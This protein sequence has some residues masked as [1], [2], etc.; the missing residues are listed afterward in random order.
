MN[1]TNDDN[2][3][4]WLSSKEMQKSLKISDCEL[5]HLR[6]AGKLQFKKLGNAF[7]YQLPGTT[8]LLTHPLGVQL[9]DW[10][11]ARHP[12]DINNTPQSPTTVKS[13][14]M[15]VAELLLPIERKFGRILITYG[16]TSASLSRHIKKHT[17]AG[18]APN[19]DQHAAHE[20]N[21]NHTEICDRG[22][23]ACD[24]IVQNSSMAD[25]TRFIVEN[26][27]FDRLYYYGG[28]RPIHVSVNE[29]SNRHLQIMAVSTAGRRIPGRRAFGEAAVTLSKEL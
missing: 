26:L 27:N 14:E 7:M 25:V 15:L 29:Q 4:Y 19:I 11:K 12:I 2:K 24:F 18:T 3:V 17:P 23:S 20:V 16:F 13:L 9:T 21:G 6:S 28:N 8:T 10:Y 1:Q 22:G 5:M